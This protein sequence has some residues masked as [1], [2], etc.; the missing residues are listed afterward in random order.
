MSEA[1]EASRG[2]AL[3]RF[4][5]ALGYA[6]RDR[7]R[8]EAALRHSSF[9]HERAR[10]DTREAGDVDHES[11]ERLEFLGDAVLALVVAE[12]LYDAKPDWSEGDLTR[13]LHSIVEGK[14]LTALARSIGLGDVLRLGR[15]EEASQGR[16][17]AS[18]LEDAMEA[19]LGAMYQDGGQTAVADFVGRFFQEELAADA[20]RVERDPKTALQEILMKEVGS[21]PTYKMTGDSGVEGD[22]LRFEIDVCSDGVVLAS[23]IGR[24][25]RAAEKA[26]ARTALA[27][28]TAETLADGE[29]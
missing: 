27:A 20:I 18:I 14:S 19:V 7:E 25:K 8:L 1:D 2:L 16:E 24:T 5:A 15:T 4:E 3:D 17:K 9:A 12:A 26:A 23:G 28:R 6:F 13:A 21:F 22:D 10:D 11:N 29:A